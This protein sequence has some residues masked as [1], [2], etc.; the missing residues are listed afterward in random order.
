[1]YAPI[2]VPTFGYPTTHGGYWNL[3]WLNWN[4]NTHL[5]RDFNISEFWK[6]VILVNKRLRKTRKCDS[7]DEFMEILKRLSLRHD[8]QNQTDNLPLKADIFS[9]EI[10]L[11]EKNN[12]RNYKYNGIFRKKTLRFQSS[13]IPG[14]Q[15][16]EQKI[17]EIKKIWSRKIQILVFF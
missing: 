11:Q 8:K 10:S 2:C 9:W 12:P 16:I 13:K 4:M 7:H 15:K 6:N 5:C 1:M 3:I 14:I 17:R